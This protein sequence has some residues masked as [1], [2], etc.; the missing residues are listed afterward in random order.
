MTTPKNT[1]TNRPPGFDAALTAYLPQLRRKARFIK[2]TQDEADELLNETVC[3]MLRRAS[4]CRM[5]TFKTW[6]QDV[7]KST[8]YAMHKLTRQIM[9]A[10]PT[11]SMSNFAEDETSP[12][13]NVCA[14]LRTPAN[15][16]EIVDLK[17]V[18]ER[19]S[20]IP[21]GDVLLRRA[22]GEFLE[23]ISAENGTTRQNV[24]IKERKARDMLQSRL[25][26]WAA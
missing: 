6:A 20:R 26:R 19:L 1:E 3:T 2:R 10:A 8:D 5:E 16:F 22:A 17:Q 25:Q 24:Q 14:Q 12:L 13:E 23:E 11:V 21:N 15:Q 7:M 18:C 4:T 9:R